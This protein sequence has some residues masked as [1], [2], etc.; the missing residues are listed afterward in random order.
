MAA[1][2]A[3]AGGIIW[4]RRCTLSVPARPSVTDTKP[5]L[6]LSG[7]M[8]NTADTRCYP[9]SSDVD[10]FRY[11]QG[12]GFVAA[13]VTYARLPVDTQAGCWSRSE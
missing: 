11:I 1:E 4:H 13:C 12:A 6:S 8:V 10:F 2:F 3:K 5:S 7:P 9:T